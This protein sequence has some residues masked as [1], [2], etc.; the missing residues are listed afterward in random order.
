MSRPSAGDPR[1][2]RAP[3]EPGEPDERAAPRRRGS[4]PGRMLLLAASPAADPTDVADIVAPA[5]AI[6]AGI[7]AAVVLAAVLGA[8]TRYLGRRSAIVQDLARRGRR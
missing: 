7:V 8:L 6:V 1:C 5:V 4:Y 3:A 2:R